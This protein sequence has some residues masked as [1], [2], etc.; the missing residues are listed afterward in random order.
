MRQ[1]LL[2]KHVVIWQEENSSSLCATLV[3]LKYLC[4]LF[5]NHLI[6]ALIS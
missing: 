5:E 4:D 2:L 1:S 3:M 6:T